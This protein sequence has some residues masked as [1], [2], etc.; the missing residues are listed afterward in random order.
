MDIDKS[1]EL[2]FPGQ[3]RICNDIRLFGAGYEGK[4]NLEMNFG[5]RVS[6]YFPECYQ[7]V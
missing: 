6:I 3:L 2:V 1:P 4:K 7:I 5:I